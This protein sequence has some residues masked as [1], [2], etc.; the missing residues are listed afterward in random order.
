MWKTSGEE[1]ESTIAA[2]KARIAADPTN[3]MNYMVLWRF[4]YLYSKYVRGDNTPEHAKYLGYLD[5]REL[6]PDIKPRS[7]KSF[8]E[9]LVAGKVQKPYAHRFGWKVS[10][11]YEQDVRIMLLVSKFGGWESCFVLSLDHRRLSGLGFRY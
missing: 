2:T 8:F 3:Q 4:Q 1:I 5:A 10:C 11:T 9:E 7:F 6:Y